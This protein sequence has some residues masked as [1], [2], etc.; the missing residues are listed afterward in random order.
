MCLD[1]VASA[2]PLFS[3]LPGGP[4]QAR[5]PILVV[6]ASEGGILRLQILQMP[7]AVF[8]FFLVAFEMAPH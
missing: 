3:S 2:L 5:V 7:L 1:G 6:R 8:V 4:L